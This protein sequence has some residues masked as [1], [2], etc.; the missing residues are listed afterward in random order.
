MT[1]K[2]LDAVDANTNGDGFPATG[3]SKTLA[4]WGDD[5]GSGTVTVEASPDGG[6]TWI[7][8]TITGSPLALT[9]K[10]VRFIERLG[11]GMQVRATL[12]GAT[13][14]SNVSAMLFD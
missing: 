3:G 6:T 11:Q 5:F 9:A 2:L 10:G 13:A 12:T 1:T 8:L 7:G 14:P 4:V